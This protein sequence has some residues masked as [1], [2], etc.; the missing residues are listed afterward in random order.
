MASEVTMATKHAK[1][2]ARPD[3]RLS[4]FQQRV[5][6]WFPAVAL[7]IF[8]AYHGLRDTIASMVNVSQSARGS[9]FEA[10]IPSSS[11]WK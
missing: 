4:I 2:H 11:S 7:F 8:V 10:S 9:I 5:V 6:D 1:T 3:E